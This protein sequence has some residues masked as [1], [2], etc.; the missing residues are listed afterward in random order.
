VE[1]IEGTIELNRDRGTE[2]R[3]VF[4]AAK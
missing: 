4:E 3:I 1:Q 2:F